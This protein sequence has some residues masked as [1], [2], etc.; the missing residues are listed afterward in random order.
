MDDYRTKC[1]NHREINC[2]KWLT[3]QKSNGTKKEKEGENKFYKND[4]LSFASLTVIDWSFETIV[5]SKPHEC[6]IY[7]F[8]SYFFFLSPI[9]S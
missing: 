3:I 9:F 4:W 2:H 8:S 6:P 7:L 5:R 1:G